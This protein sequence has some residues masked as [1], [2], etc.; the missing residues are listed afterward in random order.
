MRGRARATLGALGVVCVVAVF[1]MLPEWWSGPT[2]SHSIRYNIV[3]TEQFRDMVR[4]G[5]WYP[6][7]LLRSWDGLGSPTFYFYPPLWFWIAAGIDAVYLRLLPI[8]VLITAATAAALGGSGFAMWAWLRSQGSQKPI[9]FAVAY[10]VAPYHLYDIYIRGALAEALGYAMLPLAAVALDRLAQGRRGGIAMLAIA[11]AL[12]LLTHLPTA[13]V[14]AALLLVPYTLFL[15]RR[16]EDRAAVLVKASAG[17]L[18]G[19]GIAAAYWLPILGLTPSISL[20]AFTGPYF[21]PSTWFFWAPW[22]WRHHNTMPIIIPLT[23]GLALIAIFVVAKRGQGRFWAGIALAAAA[24]AGGFVPFV[25]DLPGFVHVQFPYRCL[26]V[27]EFA[28][29]TAVALAWPGRAAV[30]GASIVF[31]VFAAWL[32]LPVIVLR[33]IGT[34]HLGPAGLAEMSMQF[35]DAPEYLPKGLYLP[36]NERSVPEPERVNLPNSQL[37]RLTDGAPATIE[38]VAPAS[39]LVVVRRFYYPFWHVT[40]AQGRQVAVMAWGPDRLL[41]WRAPPGEHRYVLTPGPARGEREGAWITMISL[42]AAF[43]TVVRR[44]RA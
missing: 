24:M 44:R 22:N 35:R 42:L 43:A 6:R 20:D 2:I 10:M 21:T 27:V 1:V 8:G 11:C 25:W 18:V 33:V 39:G 34:H 16:A 40:D 31:A 37:A 4:G 12:L 30:R 38:V 9:L 13:F 14:T 41:A 29:L 23:T 3:W 28:T 5:V 15:A 17:G 7:V 19:I 26:V 32:V 36:L